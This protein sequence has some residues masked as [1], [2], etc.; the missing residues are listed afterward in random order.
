M[1][2]RVGINGCKF[3]SHRALK[4]MTSIF[5]LW[6]IKRHRQQRSGKQWQRQHGFTLIELVVVIVL[7]GVLAAV[8]VLRTFKSTDFYALGFQDETL[9]LL[10]YAQK[11][12]VAQRRTVCV[13]F[14]SASMVN[15]TIAANAGNATC[16]T[17]LVGP[18]ENCM[19]DLS[20]PTACVRARTG[21]SFSNT[22]A[23]FNFN[24]LGQPVDASGITVGSQVIQINGRASKITVEAETGYVHD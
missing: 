24:A 10:R 12:A 16:N 15:L 9:G 8:A 20:K 2:L 23:D 19:A 13:A 11:A 1:L 14:P 3:R 6:A 17:P 21:V 7:L 18:N 5:Y 22:P 4:L